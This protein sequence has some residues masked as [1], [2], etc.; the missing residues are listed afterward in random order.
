MAQAKACVT[1]GQSSA[2]CGGRLPTAELPLSLFAGELDDDAA[3]SVHLLQLG[4]RHHREAADDSG[5]FAVAAADR[6]AAIAEEKRLREELDAAEA[7]ASARAAVRAFGQRSGGGGGGKVPSAAA[8]AASFGIAC[9]DP[10]ARARLRA[11][12]EQAR[13]TRQAAELRD[14]V[15]HSRAAAAVGGAGIMPA[16][17]EREFLAE[18]ELLGR[19]KRRRRDEGHEKD[20]ASEVAKQEIVE[21]GPRTVA[22]ADAAGLNVAAESARVLS[23]GPAV[24][25]GGLSA[26]KR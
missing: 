3:G 7:C 4:K 9:V 25:G 12:V 18:A 20:E 10:V 1:N 6:M 15:E 11:D 5:G 19:D 13:K 8:A 14:E 24:A 21:Q 26:E 16:A 2:L 22:V 23:H 17:M